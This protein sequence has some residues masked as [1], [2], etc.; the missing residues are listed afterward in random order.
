MLQG[1]TWL[2]W[3]HIGSGNQSRYKLPFCLC[4]SR[5]IFPIR[6][7]MTQVDE[8]YMV[9]FFEYQIIDNLQPIPDI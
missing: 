4:Y 6:A 5:S 7:N 8:D 2:S 9:N 1:L 3:L